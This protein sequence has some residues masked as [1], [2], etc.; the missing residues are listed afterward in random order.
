MF[1]GALVAWGLVGPL[2][3]AVGWI[4]LSPLSSNP[5]GGRG[6]NLWISLSILL[7]EAFVTAALALRGMLFSTPQRVSTTRVEESDGGTAATATAATAEAAS[8]AV[9]FTAGVSLV[10]SVGSEAGYDTESISTTS[11]S[12]CTPASAAASVAV[13]DDE[14]GGEGN[15][16]PNGNLRGGCDAAAAL[17]PSFVAQRQLDRVERGGVTEVLPSR[18]WILGLCA[19]SLL[20]VLVLV[21][22]G[23]VGVGEAVLSVILSL[24]ISVVAVRV[25]GET[26]LNPVSGLGKVTQVVFGALFPANLVGNVIAGAVAE[27]GAQQSGDLMQDLKTGYLLGVPLPAQFT[28]QCLGSLVSV[29]ASVAAFKIMDG[30]YGVPSKT[31]GAPTAALWVAMAELMSGSGLPSPVIGLMCA[32]GLLSLWVTLVTATWGEDSSS[33]SSNRGAPRKFSLQN[34]APYL[35]SPAAFSVGMYV[36]ANWTLPR[37]AGAMLASWLVEKKGLPMQ[38]VILIATGLVLGEGVTAL[39]TAVMSTA[40][41]RPISC[42]GCAPGL[43]GNFCD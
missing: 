26:D 8:T 25:L 41:A 11:F 28:G 18:V 5:R 32:G 31:L 7:T 6:F 22:I 3:A 17:T 10:D 14:S 33:S 1:L 27:A 35:P 9:R 19:S 38:T 23:G 15:V 42:L 34:L 20:A 13:A 30:A 43:C 36:T 40:G 12:T 2:G 21:P 37:L 29:F 16:D 39:L 24:P 4:T